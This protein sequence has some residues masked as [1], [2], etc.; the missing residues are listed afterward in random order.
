MKDERRVV[1]L[2]VPPT[3]TA[4]QQVTGQREDSRLLAVYP[5]RPD[6]GDAARSRDINRRRIDPALHDQ[7]SRA[8]IREAESKLVRTITG[9]QQGAHGTCWHAEESRCQLGPVR[10]DDG[11]AVATANAVCIE[12]RNHTFDL[13]PETRIR[14]RRSVRGW[15]SRRFR[16]TLCRIAQEAADGVCGNRA[17]SPDAYVVQTPGVHDGTTTRPTL[18]VSRGTTDNNTGRPGR[19]TRMWCLVWL[20]KWAGARY[21]KKHARQKAGILCS[22]A[23]FVL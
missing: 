19:D 6:D 22:R 17:S 10:K 3:L 18:I 20:G 16:V 11:Y 9:V 12:P 2:G 14:Q 4:D 7:R 23:G 1:R 15:E 8:E 21:S 5:S 13:T